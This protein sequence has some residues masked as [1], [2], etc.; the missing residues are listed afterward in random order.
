[1]LK[2]L[3][4][5]TLRQKPFLRISKMK[6]SVMT[7]VAVIL[8]SFN[9]FP[10]A[11]WDDQNKPELFETNF[12]RN[13]SKLPTKGHLK[14]LPW[15]D[16]YWA[17]FRGGIT[18]RWNKKVREGQESKRWN[19]D[20]EEM[21][22]I[23]T[24]IA[25]L[26][27]AE[28]YDLYLGQ[29]Q[30]PLTNYER[31][32]TQ[33]MKTVST[34]P[35]YDKDFKIPEWEGLCHG[36]APATLLF[37]NSEPITVVGKLG[38]KISFGSSD[39][40]ALLTYHMHLNPSRKTNFLGS[41]CNLDFKELE[42][43]YEKRE[44]TRKELEEKFNSA[45]CKDTNAGAFHVAITNQIG[46]MDQGFVVD[47]TRD[48]EV[49]NQPVYSF[50]SHILKV[51]NGATRGAAPGTVKEITVFT[52]MG[53][54]Q[55]IQQ[56]Y[57][58]LDKPIY[59]KYEKYQYRLE[60]NNDGEIIGGEWESFDRPDFIWKT[61]AAPFTGYFK[62]L[63]KLYKKSIQYL[64][65]S[66]FTPELMAKMQ[67]VGRISLIEREFIK[68][69][70][71]QVNLS[72]LK[73]EANRVG[74]KNLSVLA[75]KEAGE[76]ER[77]ER[78]TAD[79]KKALTDV[80]K[81]LHKK[82][83]AENFIKRMRVESNLTNV[84]EVAKPA[85]L[86][87]LFVTE[88]RKDA[89]ETRNLKE[90][91]KKAAK[92]EVKLEAAGEFLKKKFVT[93]V[94]K[95]AKT[96]RATMESNKAHAK[97]E[98]K[99][100]ANH[101]FYGPKFVNEVKTLAD[102]TRIKKAHFNAA[103]REVFVDAAGKYLA[104]KFVVEV[105]KDAKASRELKEAHK[106]HA[107]AELKKLANH[108]FYGPRFVNEVQT[109][110]DITRKTKEAARIAAQLKLDQEFMVVVKEGN[111]AK[112]EELLKKGA[113]PGFISEEG[114]TALM[115]AVQK[116]DKGI[117]SA[118]LKVMDLKAINAVDKDGR[119]ALILAIISPNQR[120]DRDSRKLIRELL[121]KN[122]DVN[123]KDNSGK[124]ALAYVTSGPYKSKLIEWALKE[125]GAKL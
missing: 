78:I 44:I 64:G 60:L 112:T 42:K 48:S 121:E 91:H 1:M 70:K 109:L 35:D 10:M 34:S 106:A 92:K 108:N 18:Y 73:E 116:E 40:H 57:E 55:E 46:L 87:N 115:I 2:T 80:K 22:R 65:P 74:I 96:T 38:H 97:E 120:P 13:F 75:F 99:K 86:A 95:D 16:D 113:N 68:D 100:F 31:N 79:I 26:S 12:E 72:K 25:D 29:D 77:K 62:E 98:L 54:V 9:A 17:T 23:T 59:I 3:P 85:G 19:Y 32:R 94:S 69:A 45:E 84:R 122:I 81:E 125:K 53:F 67:R 49:W 71:T 43:K 104:N 52:K 21:D 103:K 107:K 4:D 93:E 11:R 88:V 118:L 50:E 89:I 56:T 124:T 41:R 123:L 33:I 83:L 30:Y 66:K 111:L 28:K 37:R 24:P 5:D 63:E 47:I 36:W 7:L 20:I 114:K 6:K 61:T 27:P 39:L 105:S 51:N 110:A 58:V 119:N 14:T 8:C 117:I 15:S 101:N 82:Y 102:A 90:A 76:K